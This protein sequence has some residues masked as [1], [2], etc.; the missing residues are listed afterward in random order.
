MRLPV[1]VGTRRNGRVGKPSAGLNGAES[2]REGRSRFEPFAVIAP[3]RYVD[4]FTMGRREGASGRKAE[5]DAAGA[6]PRLVPRGEH[7][8]DA[9][10]KRLRKAAAENCPSPNDAG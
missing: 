10:V 9:A 8:E 6:A 5:W 3:K 4:L 2:I 7:P 1:F